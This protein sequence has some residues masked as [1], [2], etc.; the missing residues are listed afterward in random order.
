MKKGFTLIEVLITG[1]IMSMVLAGAGMFISVSSKI[2]NKGLLEAKAQNELFLIFNNIERDIR[3]GIKISNISVQGIPGIAIYDKNDVIQTV[4]GDFGGQLY[5]AKKTNGVPNAND[6]KKV[7]G[8]YET[9]DLI[10]D[11]FDDN[12]G[13]GIIGFKTVRIRLQLK[14]K[15][16]FDNS[17]ITTSPIGGVIHVKSN[18]AS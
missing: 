11:N 12:I 2:V 16:N 1:I 18:K 8:T 4:Y 5:V 10:Y 3:K 17:Q 6:F 7:A 14:A 9:L 13:N 15:N